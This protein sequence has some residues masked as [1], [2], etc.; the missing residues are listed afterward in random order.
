M[1]VIR[2]NAAALVILMLASASLSGA[3]FPTENVQAALAILSEPSA[4]TP[5]DGDVEVADG[6]FRHRSTC[7]QLRQRYQ[8]DD[9][10]VPSDSTVSVDAYENLQVDAPYG[11]AAVLMADTEDGSCDYQIAAVPTLVLET[12]AA[13]RIASFASVLCY[14]LLGYP[15]VGSEFEQAGEPHALNAIL[16]DPESNNWLIAIGP[17]SLEEALASEEEPGADVTLGTFDAVMEDGHLIGDGSS[18]AG[19]VHVELRCTPFRPIFG[20]TG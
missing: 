7:D 12:S 2:R 17:G 14:S 5:I 4:P 6:R 19:P 20:A 18:D 1:P 8:A 3:G 10:P 9:A 13:G 15:A 11:P 16:T